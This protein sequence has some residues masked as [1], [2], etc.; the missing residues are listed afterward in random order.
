[1][2]EGGDGKRG[3]F[4]S[5]FEILGDVWVRFFRDI[6]LVVNG[7]VDD[8]GTDDELSLAIKLAE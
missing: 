7:G 5:S 1:M 4:C 6:G 8:N 2:P 3:K